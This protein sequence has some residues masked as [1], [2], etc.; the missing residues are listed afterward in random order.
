L[1]NNSFYAPVQQELEIVDKLM[2]KQAADYHADL[3]KA[4][5]IILSSGGKRLRAAVTLL[6]G[7]M[8]GA[9]QELNITL[10]SAIEMLHTAT[11]VHDDLIDGALL[12]RG[13]PTLN[14]QWSPGATVLTGDFL[15]A[16][17]AKLAADTNSVRVMKIFSET[18]GVIVNGEI[19]QLFSKRYMVDRQDYYKRIYAKTASLFETSSRSAAILSNSD[20]I[21]IT[22]MAQYGY[23]IGM[24]FQIIDDIL[25][26]NG[27]QVTLGK[28]VGS[29]LRQ[30]LITLP[31]LYYVENHPNDPNVTCLLTNKCLEDEHQTRELI[32]AVSN[33][34]AIQDSLHE[35][36]DFVEKG[37]N[38]LLQQPKNDFRESLEN[39]SRYIVDRNV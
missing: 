30:G 15:F 17:A 16:R 26:F 21:T 27:E 38:F 11:L 28:P 13:M 36:I 5:D 25:D 20:E 22:N 3:Q 10:A 12:R 2:R 14:S 4:L 1:I 18:L 23:N 29:D 8:L 37:L 39:L 33:S 9:D 31:T 19:S 35:A 7:K 6:V 32:R 24:A 34:T